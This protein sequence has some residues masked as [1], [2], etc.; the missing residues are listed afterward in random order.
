MSTSMIRFM[1]GL[2]AGSAG[3][4]MVQKIVRVR[5]ESRY[6]RRMLKHFRRLEKTGQ[7]KAYF[8]ALGGEKA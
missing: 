7:N 6:E 4:F 2:V 8:S 3:T 1:S 5:C